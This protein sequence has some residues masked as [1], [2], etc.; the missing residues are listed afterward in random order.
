MTGSIRTFPN[1]LASACFLGLTGALAAGPWGDQGDGTYRNPVLNGDFA[2]SDIEKLGDTWYLITSTNHLAPG[3]TILESKD[4]VNWQYTGHVWPELTWDP[5]YHW[6]RMSGYR[7]GVWAGDL[8]Y[9]DGEWLCYQIDFQSGLYMSKA[10]DIRGPWSEPVCLLK[11]KHWTDPAVYFDEDKKEAWLVCNWGKGSPP[12][13]DVPHEIKLFKLSWDGTRLLD[14]GRTIHTGPATEAAKIR[15]F[16]GQWY[17]MLIEWQG[18]GENRDRK[19]LCL[20]SKTDSIYGPYESKV[21][22]ERAAAPDRSACQG[23]LVEAPDGSWW[24]M[25]QLVQN[26]EPRYQGRPQCLEPVNWVDGWPIIGRDIDDDGIGEPVESWRK[27]VASKPTERLS[28]SD[29]FDGTEIGAQW[30]WNHNP[31]NKRWSLTDR[32]GWLRLTASK[33]APVGRNI[34]GR[35]A[36]PKAPFWRAS[37]TLSQRHLGLGKGLIEAHLD[38]TGMRPGQQAGICHHSG[39]F[40]LFGVS[41]DDQGATTLGL[42]IN[43]DKTGG[44][45]VGEDVIFLLSEIDGPK[46]TFAFSFDGQHWR[47]FGGTATLQFG[48][49]RGTRPGLYSFNT[50]TDDPGKAGFVDVDYFRY[51]DW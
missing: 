17:I 8:A 23:S 1:L 49:W 14:E 2:D 44:Y 12:R 18:E 10:R 27:P 28:A 25:H 5:H 30:N 9:R 51:T 31:R 37:N 35:T 42:N 48:N 38:L 3:M 39:Q 19:Q 26:G 50:K 6:D 11:R 41:V 20:R 40:V 4:L 32:P 22:M 47:D 15:R 24:F 33:P 46:A 45:P 36:G 16:N 13:R 21:V 34:D 29:E 7:F 43:G